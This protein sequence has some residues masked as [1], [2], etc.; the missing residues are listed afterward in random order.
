[1]PE[2][3]ASVSAS[4]PRRVFG[5]GVLLL[6]GGMVLYLGLGRSHQAPGWQL[7]LLVFGASVLWMADRMRR[8]TALRLDLTQDGLFDSA[9]RELARIDQI[10]AVERGTFAAKPSNGFVLRLAERGPRAWAPGLWW[11]A[12]RRV[13]IGGVTSA[14]QTKFMAEMLTALLAERDRDADVSS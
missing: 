3:L 8:A 7:F 5:I 6:L 11:R 10:V 12:G 4:L 14:G 9:G 13:G 1:M 2:V